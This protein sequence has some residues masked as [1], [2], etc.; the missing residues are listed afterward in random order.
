MNVSAIG[1][2]SGI[3]KLEA[4]SVLRL[5]PYSPV[6]FGLAGAD[7]NSAGRANLLSIV[8]LKRTVE[9]ALQNSKDIQLAEDPDPRRR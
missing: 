2:G 7:R 1:F 9:L 5:W 6:S 4:M 8:T 3:M